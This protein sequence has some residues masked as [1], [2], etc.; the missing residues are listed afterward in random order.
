[1][2]FCTERPSMIMTD[3]QHH[4]AFRRAIRSSPVDLFIGWHRICYSEYYA[5]NR[6]GI[7]RQY[8]DRFCVH[9]EDC[10]N[11]GIDEQCQTLQQLDERIQIR[12]KEKYEDDPI[13][14]KFAF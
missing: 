13:M 7:V 9:R 1:M 8:F 10:V 5:L 3:R 4:F 12:T 11:R 6:S 2:P 14:H